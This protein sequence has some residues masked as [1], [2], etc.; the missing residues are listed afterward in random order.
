MIP[1]SSVTRHLP[2]SLRQRRPSQGHV[3]AG[4]LGRVPVAG[5]CVVRSRCVR[6]VAVCRQA[7]LQDEGYV[8][9]FRCFDCICSERFAFFCSHTIFYLFSF[10][11]CLHWKIRMHYRAH[12]YH[13]SSLSRIHSCTDNLIFPPCQSTYF[14]CCFHSR[15]RRTGALC[16]LRAAHSANRQL[17][18]GCVRARLVAYDDKAMVEYQSIL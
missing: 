3:F 6:V 16:L 15:P 1:L 2:K 12:P 17:R 5:H 9:Y 7:D 11:L 4:V 18:R 13:V 8:R 14:S 10:G